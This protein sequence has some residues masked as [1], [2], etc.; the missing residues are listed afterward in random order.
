MTGVPR[1]TEVGRLLFSTLGGELME[2]SV[3]GLVEIVLVF[4]GFLAFI[5]WQLHDLKKRAQARAQGRRPDREG[6]AGDQA[7]EVRG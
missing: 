6:A 3:L 5:H 4:G 7:D 2:G 1:E